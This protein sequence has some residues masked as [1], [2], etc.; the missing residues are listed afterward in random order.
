MTDNSTADNGGGA[1][2]YDVSNIGRIQ[3]RRSDVPC[4]HRC[5]H[6]LR[7]FAWRMDASATL[8]AVVLSLLQV[9]EPPTSTVSP[10]SCGTGTY[11][12]T[13]A[14]ESC[15][16]GGSDS[17]AGGYACVIGCNGPGKLC[18]ADYPSPVGAPGIADLQRTTTIPS[19][20]VHGIPFTTDNSQY[21]DMYDDAND[22]ATVHTTH[23]GETMFSGNRGTLPAG[24]IRIVCPPIECLLGP[25]PPESRGCRPMSESARHRFNTGRKA[26]NNY[27]NGLCVRT[28]DEGK[29]CGGYPNSKV[30]YLCR[31]CQRVKGCVRS[32][33]NPAKVGLGYVRCEQRFLHGIGGRSTRNG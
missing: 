25:P 24:A 18:G 21:R 5:A 16:S 32:G 2:T 8:I 6:R 23:Q 10:V 22:S 26:V 11:C 31:R 27:T 1:T 19:S 3:C 15:P 12:R 30:L 17:C 33:F 14:C 9:I 28:S 29:H 4:L 7:K 13:G 20:T